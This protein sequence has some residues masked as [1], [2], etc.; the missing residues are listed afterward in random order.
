MTVT[1]P[2]SPVAGPGALPGAGPTECCPSHD[3]CRGGRMRPRAANV[4]RLGVWG[5]MPCPGKGSGGALA[6][7]LG[8]GSQTVMWRISRA[9]RDQVGT[10]RTRG[11]ARHSVLHG[12][13]P[14]CSVPVTTALP[15]RP[16]VS[17]TQKLLGLKKF[18]VTSNYFLAQFSVHKKLE[19]KMQRFLTHSPPPTPSAVPAASTPHQRGPLVIPMNLCRHVI[20]TQSSQLP[21]GSRLVLDVLWVWTDA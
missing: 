9:P 4:L 21:S 18:R 3:G 5:T 13:R 19:R 12:A 15:A 17:H 20:V 6:P 2:P 16:S 8:G 1:S 10:G 7:G 11:T 14:G